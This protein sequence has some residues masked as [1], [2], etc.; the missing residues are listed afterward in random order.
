MSINER[1][2]VYISENTSLLIVKPFSF[3][4][5]LYVCEFPFN[6]P[7]SVLK[8]QNLARSSTTLPIMLT[9]SDSISSLL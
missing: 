1:L 8:I 4:S 2:S 9:G 6:H 7:F 5:V 3:F